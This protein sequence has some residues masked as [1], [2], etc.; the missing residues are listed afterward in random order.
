MAVGGKFMQQKNRLLFLSIAIAAALVISSC[1][2]VYKLDN[3][4]VKSAAGTEPLMS[5]SFEP[6]R[7][8]SVWTK[9]RPASDTTFFFGSLAVNNA[10]TTKHIRISAI[11]LSLGDSLVSSKEY[12]LSSMSVER[13]THP[14]HTSYYVMTPDYDLQSKNGINLA[15]GHPRQFN[16]WFYKIHREHFSHEIRLYAEVTLEENGQVRREQCVITYK[17]RLQNAVPW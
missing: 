4:R 17:K 3:F 8:V 13:R 6:Y 1:A 11:K 5:V 14:P 9:K 7:N 12:A 16:F 10:D 2:P 15:D